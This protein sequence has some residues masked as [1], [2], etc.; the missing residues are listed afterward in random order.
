MHIHHHLAVMVERRLGDGPCRPGE[1]YG[2][3]HQRQVQLTMALKLLKGLQT[4]MAEFQG[5]QGPAEG[6]GTIPNSS[7]PGLHHEEAG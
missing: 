1:F 5:Q 4:Q 7:S 3:D 2:P 6:P